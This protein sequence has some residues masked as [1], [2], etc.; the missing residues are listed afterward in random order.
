M[1]R[2]PRFQPKI[3]STSF[4][5]KNTGINIEASGDAFEAKQDGIIRIAFQN[6]HGTSDLRGLA[7]PSEVEAMDELEVDIMGMA[8]T[9]KPWTNQQ[10]SLYDTYLNKRFRAARTLYTAAPPQ[11]HS[12]KY[13]PPGGNLLTATGEVTAR[14]DGRGTDTMGRFCW[15]TFAGKRDEGIIVI[16]AYRVCQ[17]KTN[18]PGPL[19]VFQQ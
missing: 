13:Q 7:V 5:G 15:Y 8:E 11:N 3:T 10:K 17:E 4:T 6:I 18:G 19:T 1:T 16:V 12:I 9:N 2:T 14:I